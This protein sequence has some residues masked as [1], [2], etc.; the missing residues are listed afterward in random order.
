MVEFAG[1]DPENGDALFVTNTLNDDGSRDKSLTNNFNDATRVVL[2]SPFPDLIAGFTNNL[3]YKNV[4][5]S[6]TFQG[7]W[8]ASIYN[9]GG[10]FQSA[11]ADF[12]DNQSLDQL[13]RWQQ[14]GDI[15]DVPQ[16]R[17]F[18]ANGTQSSSRYLQEADFIR[19]R[20][21]TLGYSLPASFTNKMNIDRLRIY[22]T[23]VNLLTFTD[24]DGYDPESTYDVQANSN[25]NVGNAFYSAPPAKTMT[26]GVN[27][28]F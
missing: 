7:Q 26:I 10:R 12:F 19:L 3:Y 21:I 11:S 13:D 5:L 8:G 25:I 27:F 1:A 23:A 18:G 6:F 2:G 9:A 16:A 24:Y 14:P 17:L 28:E 4:D 15:T 20:N 22:F